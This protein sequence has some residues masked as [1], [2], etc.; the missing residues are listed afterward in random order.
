MQLLLILRRF[1]VTTFY[2]RRFRFVLWDSLEY[3]PSYHSRATSSV[4]Q[5]QACMNYAH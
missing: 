1:Q 2:L 3:L 5:L 4:I